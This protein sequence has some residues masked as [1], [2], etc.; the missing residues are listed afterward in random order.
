VI[1][2]GSL[3]LYVKE[4]SDAGTLYVAA[5]SVDNLPDPINVQT[6]VIT[7]AFETTMHSASQLSNSIG[8]RDLV[9]LYVN[10][11]PAH[12]DRS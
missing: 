4:G 12:G 10:A 3:G 1:T 9:R 8:G 5:L 6:V 11:Q 7:G 2:G